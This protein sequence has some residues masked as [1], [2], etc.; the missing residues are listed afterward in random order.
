MRL[1]DLG[2]GT[3]TVICWVISKICSKVSVEEFKIEDLSFKGAS[4]LASH[5]LF[6][7]A[8][9]LCLEFLGSRV[10]VTMKSRA[11][12]PER[13]RKQN[14]WGSEGGKTQEVE[15]VFQG[16]ETISSQS[17]SGTIKPLRKAGPGEQGQSPKCTLKV[18]WAPAESVVAQPAPHTAPAT[19]MSSWLTG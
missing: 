16:R 13:K 5:P 6:P 2:K 1:K 7:R 11:N 10:G 14:S 18:S 17:S 4:N 8:W 3:N 15:Y 19:G 12:L 9:A